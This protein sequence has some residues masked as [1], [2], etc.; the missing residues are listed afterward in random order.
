[1][2]AAFP[3]R[4]K[5]AVKVARKRLR[6]VCFGD[7]SPSSSS[8][9]LSSFSLHQRLRCLA[10]CPEVSAVMDVPPPNPP[11]ADSDPRRCRTAGG[12]LWPG[13]LSC[14]V[15]RRRRGPSHGGGGVKRMQMLTSRD[16]SQNAQ[17]AAP[18]PPH[19]GREEELAHPYHPKHTSARPER[20][21]SA[22]L[23]QRSQ[24]GLIRSRSWWWD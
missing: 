22:C 8:L 9:R 4:R 19:R 12:G 6:D 11:T 23:Q 1:M 24:M 18:A 2:V 21:R 15:P 5:H 17:A 20:R 16:D 3:S 14:H 10:F 13:S 7:V